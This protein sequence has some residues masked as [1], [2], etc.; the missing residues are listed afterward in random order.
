MGKIGKLF[1]LGGREDLMSEL[2]D[3]RVLFAAERT[4]LAWTR[5]MAAIWQFRRVVPTLKPIEIP[6]GYRINFGVFTNV[7][8]VLLGTLLIVYP[9]A[10]GRIH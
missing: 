9:V 8:V 5:T 4:L 10:R 6:H 3:P 7:V 2:N 1:D